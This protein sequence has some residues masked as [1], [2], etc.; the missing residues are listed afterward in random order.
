[1]QTKS[2]SNNREKCLQI[3]TVFNSKF[4]RK[5][6][7]TSQKAVTLI[8]KTQVLASDYKL[9]TLLSLIWSPM[10]CSKIRESGKKNKYGA[11]YLNGAK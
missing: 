3:Q 6:L 10:Q 5:V 4:V 7:S 8:L 1:V 2:L 9:I 11:D